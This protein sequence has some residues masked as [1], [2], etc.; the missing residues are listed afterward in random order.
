M[1]AS[2]GSS[3]RS[4]SLR[5]FSGSP[6]SWTRCL[7]RVIAVKAG[8]QA[9]GTTGPST[10]STGSCPRCARS[11]VD[12][13]Q[14][15]S[16]RILR[17][18]NAA[19][20]AMQPTKAPTVGCSRLEGCPGGSLP[21]ARPA[22][23]ELRAPGVRHCP[24]SAGEASLITRHSTLFSVTSPNS[25]PM[26]PSARHP[27]RPTRSFLPGRVRGGHP[28]GDGSTGG[29]ASFL[30]RRC[31]VAIA[32]ASTDLGHIRPCGAR[33]TSCSESSTIQR[34]L[35]LVARLTDV[36]AR[37]F[38]A[39]V[40]DELNRE[41]GFRHPGVAA[42]ASDDLEHGMMY[43][44]TISAWLDAM[45]DVVAASATLGVD[46]NTLRYR[47]ALIRRPVRHQHGQP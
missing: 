33:S 10:G 46:P 37:V 30:R 38:L 13:A 22:G 8:S 18:D 15:A 17:S 24:R 41:P 25:G 9:P 26:P 43:T 35:P 39:H 27:G 11:I 4:W 32:G 3:G 19:A 1:V 20:L 42:M 6:R 16:L 21:A 28:P 47:L 45:G 5:E 29:P 7:G 23:V 36:H 40:V 12:G 31:R 34:D 14:H 44:S 2:P